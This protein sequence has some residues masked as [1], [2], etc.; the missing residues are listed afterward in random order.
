MFYL[1]ISSSSDSEEK[2]GEIS[3]EGDIEEKTEV[4]YSSYCKN[5]LAYILMVKFSS[6]EMFCKNPSF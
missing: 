1:A 5:S 2:D 6:C 4:V 3:E